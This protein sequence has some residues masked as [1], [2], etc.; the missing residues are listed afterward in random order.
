MRLYIFR[1]RDPGLFAAGPDMYVRLQLPRIV[2]RPGL[3]R[4]RAL[5]PLGLV[6]NAR[7]APWAECVELRPSSVLF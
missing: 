5:A 3:N 1:N 4:H 2:Q 6:V 7:A